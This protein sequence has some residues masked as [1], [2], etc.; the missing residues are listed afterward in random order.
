MGKYL[1]KPEYDYIGDFTNSMYVFKING[2]YGAMNENLKIEIEPTYY[3][4][5][6]YS[7]DLALVKKDQS[8]QYFY[9]DKKGNIIIDQNKLGF[10]INKANSFSEGFAFVES[11]YTRYYIDTTGKIVY[12]IPEYKIKKFFEIS[13]GLFC[14][15][16]YFPSRGG[17][18]LY[19]FMNSKGEI[20]IEPKFKSAGF[21]SE[22][23]C[24]VKFDNEKYGYID[25]KGKTILEA[26]YNDALKFN[27]SS[28]WVLVEGKWGMI[29]KQGKYLINPKYS[30]KYTDLSQREY[31]VYILIQ[32]EIYKYGFS[33]IYDEKNNS[34][35]WFDSKGK[36]ISGN[37]IY[38]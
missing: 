20:V 37:P 34:T 30:Q 6:D 32:P 5:N 8:G 3:A 36:I 23:L 33:K 38:K 9:I 24:A 35:I 22:G 28:A 19:G 10:K 26:E 2:R 25:N 31:E 21:F 17:K 18:Y 7:S 16:A 27:G 15:E 12:T 29:N 13:E 14:F 4:F 11:D 1:L